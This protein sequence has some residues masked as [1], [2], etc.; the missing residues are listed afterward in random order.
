M[1]AVT[2]S[3]Y[4]STKGANKGKTMPKLMFDGAGWQGIS[5]ALVR[6]ILN[7]AQ[8]FTNIVSHSDAELVAMSV[9]QDAAIAQQALTVNAA[10]LGVVNTPVLSVQGDKLDAILN[11]L[12]SQDARLKEVER[13]TQAA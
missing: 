11:L 7:N 12:T 10:N 5:P 3:T 6:T 4:A 1:V 13:F 9:A 2:I 8:A